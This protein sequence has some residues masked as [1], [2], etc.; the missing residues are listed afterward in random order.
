MASTRDPDTPAGQNRIDTGTGRAELL[1]RKRRVLSDYLAAG[2]AILRSMADPDEVPPTEDLAPLL[3]R[4]DLALAD[5]RRLDARLSDC[6]PSDPAAELVADS[7][8]RR[9]L[10]ASADQDQVLS[11]VFVTWR[12]SI[13]GALSDIASGRKALKGYRSTT[14][15]SHN[16]VDEAA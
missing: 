16:V 11:D 12:E 7:A 8:L 4:R 14:T 10:E 15:S 6:L 5:I 2:E 3:T 1:N 9:A 13:A